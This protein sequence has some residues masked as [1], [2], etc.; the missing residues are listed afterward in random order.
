MNFKTL[1]KGTLVAVLVTGL[2]N[3]ILDDQPDWSY[4]VI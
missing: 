4:W 1:F 2:T 3:G